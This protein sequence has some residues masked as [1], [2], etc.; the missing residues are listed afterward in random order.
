MAKTASSGDLKSGLGRLE[1]TLEVYFVDKA[2]FQLPAGAKEFI[3]KY[4]PWITLILLILTLPALLLA[5]GL[6]ALVARFAF[7]GGLQAGVSYGVGMIF[8]AVILV[9]EAFAIPGLLKRKLGGWR[10]MYWAALLG[11][12]ENLISFNLGGLIIGTLLS[13]YIIFQV[14]SYYK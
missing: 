2:P 3:V 5:F 7:L 13:L 11:A 10:L 4:G 6:G 14:K 12:V 1:S 8:S 9:M